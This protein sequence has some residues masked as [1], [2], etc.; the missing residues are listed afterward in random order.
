MGLLA[1]D[2]LRGSLDED[3]AEDAPVLLQHPVD[4]RGRLVGIGKHVEG[5]E[6]KA[7]IDAVVGKRERAPRRCSRAR[8]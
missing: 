6:G 2:L 8:R 4:L 7:E 1:E 3:G 5:H